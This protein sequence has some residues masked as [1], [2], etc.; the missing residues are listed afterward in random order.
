MIFLGYP[1]DP[2]KGNIIVKVPDIYVN[3]IPLDITV[4]PAL[5]HIPIV[6]TVG[7]ITVPVI[8]IPAAPGFG[9]FTTD[10]SSGFFNTG[11][12][13]ESGIGN[14]GVNNSGFLNFGALQSGMANLGN[15]IS[16]FY[17]TSALGLLTPGLVSG[18]G[19]IGREVAGFFN[20]GL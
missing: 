4:G 15:T 10:P 9:S 6:T 18:V 3:N 20:A 19:N 13:G 11:G 8:H 17:N 14:F 16:G 12:G 2:L 1:R 7:P 5:M